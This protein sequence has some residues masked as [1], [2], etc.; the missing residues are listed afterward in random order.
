MPSYY[1][2]LENIELRADYTEGV[3]SSGE[4]GEPTAHVVSVNW[5]GMD[6]QTLMVAWIG[7]SIEELEED[8]TA[9]L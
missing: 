5:N 6:V 1:F 4:H 7:K 2:E 9:T 8:I 3:T